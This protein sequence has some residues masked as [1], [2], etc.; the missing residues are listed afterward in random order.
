MITGVCHICE[1]EAKEFWWDG[2][3]EGWI[4]P[5]CQRCLEKKLGYSVDVVVSTTGT[6]EYPSVSWSITRVDE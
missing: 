5:I 4:K 1:A 3:Q 2:G 6:T